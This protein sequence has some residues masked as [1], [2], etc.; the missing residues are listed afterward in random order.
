MRFSVSLLTCAL[1]ACAPTDL[2]PGE[3]ADDAGEPT[4]RD[5]DASL[6]EDTSRPDVTPDAARM[7]CDAELVD[8]ARDP[9]HCGGCDAPCLGLC[10]G[11][12]CDDSTMG[13]ELPSRLLPRCDTPFT[14]CSDGCRGDDE[15]DDTCIDT[16]TLAPLEGVGC[17]RCL[18]V[19]GVAC[20]ERAGCEEE[21]ASY[22]ACLQSHCAD[23]G[24]SQVC[25]NDKC[26]D[27]KAAVSDCAPD[28]W[29]VDPGDPRTACIAD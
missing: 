9:R 12:T 20:S 7:V 17:R 29:G 15:C 22:V 2:P 5:A 3:D 6:S 11:G 19:Q 18:H 13:P 27:P 1:V 26:L 21:V 25:I 28:C 24:G 16:Y 23:N 10:V 8:T 14:Q 4:F